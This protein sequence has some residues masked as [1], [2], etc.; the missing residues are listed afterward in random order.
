MS[1]T[2]S[3]RYANPGAPRGAEPSSGKT[4]KAPHKGGRKNGGWARWS[5]S[6]P[7]HLNH[8][9]ERVGHPWKPPVPRRFGDLV[10]DGNG[11]AADRY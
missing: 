8:S 11:V 2:V 5:R 6:S 10:E 4:T 7:D 1:Q 9:V 3:T